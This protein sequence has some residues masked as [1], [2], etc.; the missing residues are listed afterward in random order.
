VPKGYS[1]ELSEFLRYKTAKDGLG[2]VLAKKCIAANI[3]STMIAKLLNVSRQTVYAWF[4]GAEI[5]SERVPS[6]EALIRII[7]KDIADK[8]LPLKDYKSSKDYYKN[9]TG[10][11]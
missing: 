11:A 2:I 6:V 3:P 10:P 8:V 5:Q 1:S 9:L 4:R 7:D